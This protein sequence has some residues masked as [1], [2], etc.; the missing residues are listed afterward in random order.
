MK[1]LFLMMLIFGSVFYGK[2]IVAEGESCPSPA[3]ESCVGPQV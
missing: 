1:K 2:A 3:L